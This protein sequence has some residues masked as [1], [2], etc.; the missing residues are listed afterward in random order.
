MPFD[1][2]GQILYYTGPTPARPA[3]PSALQGRPRV[4]GW[5]ST[6]LSPGAGAQSHDR[7]RAAG[8]GG[9]GCYQKIKSDLLAAIGGAGALISKAIKK[10]EVVAY[11]ELGTEAVLRLRWRTSPP[12]S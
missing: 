7:E 4:T 6:H 8:S 11:P 5:T 2:K 10:A 1:L 12:S 3:G 9:K